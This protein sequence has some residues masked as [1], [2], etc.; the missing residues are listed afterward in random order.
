MRA[1]RLAAFS[2]AAT[3]LALGA[4]VLAGGAPP[5][6]WSTVP[7][8]GLPAAAAAVLSRRRRG[9]LELVVVLG[10]VQ[11]VLHELFTV[12][13]STP[14]PAAPHHH[15][16]VTSAGESSWMLAAHAG[17]V[18]VT[19]VLLARGDQMLCLLQTWWNALPTVVRGLPRPAVPFRPRPAVPLGPP[20]HELPCRRAGTSVVRRGP[21]VPVC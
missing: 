18:I 11:L 8:V 6:V 12:C 15:P 17:A 19:A 2:T 10:A 13:A 9:A 16:Q 3:V 4:H 14:G 1:L 5:S 7:A 21:P 20:L